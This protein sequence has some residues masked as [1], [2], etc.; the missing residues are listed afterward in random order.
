MH[1]RISRADV[2]RMAGVA[3]STVSRALNDSSRI[4]EEVKE[5]VRNT[6]AHLGYVPNRQAALLARNKTFRIGLVVKTYKSFSPFSRAYFPRLLDGV[7]VRAEERGY[8]VNV[9]MDKA[10]DIYKDLSLLVRSREVDGLIFS[11]TPLND[12][13][14]A[15]LKKQNVPFV[16]INNKVAGFHCIN[17]S[18]EGGMRDAFNHARGLG[19]RN[20]GYIAGD[21]QYYDGSER[22]RIFREL[23]GEF[24]FHTTVIEGN[25]SKTDGRKTAAELLS[26]PL[27]RP[28]LIMCASDR[29]AL[30]VL[31]YCHFA[32]IR[33][34][35]EL[36]LIGFDN[37]GPARDVSPGL[38]TVHNP[39][40]R[41]GQESVDM[42]V[43]LLEGRNPPMYRDAESAFIIREST[44]RAMNTPGRESEAAALRKPF[45]F[46]R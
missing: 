5:R 40:T 23:A 18:A 46:N 25:F 2:A 44:S 20:I 36:S 41:M 13:R 14:F 12:D 31:D 34:P 30:G 42:L 35:E 43:D 16:L 17:C 32:G 11:V 9:V 29:S 37:L 21:T 15:D 33:V 39:V 1:K 38:T 45:T 26:D 4:S 10:G 7:L 24:N 3:E 22:L 6:A 8:S 19:H 27:Q 28:T